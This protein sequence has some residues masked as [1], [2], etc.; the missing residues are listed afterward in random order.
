MSAASGRPGLQSP[1]DP[2]YSSRRS[3][4]AGARMSPVMSHHLSKLHKKALAAGTTSSLAQVSKSSEY[5][6]GF[7]IIHSRLYAPVF[8]NCFIVRVLY[9]VTLSVIIISS[10]ARPNLNPFQAA[11]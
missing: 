4:E 6:L 2:G 3:S 8:P 10:Q 9:I 5:I 1:L 11:V 7:I